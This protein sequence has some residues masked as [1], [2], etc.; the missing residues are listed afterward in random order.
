[1]RYLHAIFGCADTYGLQNPGTSGVCRYITD[2]GTKS[3]QRRIKYVARGG[4]GAAARQ[5]RTLFHVVKVGELTDGQLL[6]RFATDGGIE[7]REVALGQS[8]GRFVE[9]KEGIKSDENVVIQPLPFVSDDQKRQM[10][11]PPTPPATKL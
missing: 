5:L 4:N 6:E 9:V 8:N 10:K 1:L 3:S 7:W 2:R 11:C